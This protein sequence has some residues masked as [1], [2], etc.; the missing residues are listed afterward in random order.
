MMCR[1]A[2]LLLTVFTWTILPGCQAESKP[3]PLT[4]EQE[5][6]LRKQMQQVQDMER[7]NL[8]PSGPDAGSD[9]R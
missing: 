5:R 4:S 2:L 7:S 1:Y 8:S 6:E 9:S 3:A